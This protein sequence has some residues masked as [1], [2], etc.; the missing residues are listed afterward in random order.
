[1]ELVGKEFVNVAK[2]NIEHEPVNAVFLLD[3][4]ISIPVACRINGAC[5]LSA[6]SLYYQD[7]RIELD[8]Q[9][10]LVSWIDSCGRSSVCNTQRTLLQNA[11]IGLNALR[12]VQINSNLQ[13]A[14]HGTALTFAQYRTLLINSA[15]GYDEQSDKPNSNGKPRRS[16]FN[17]E[18]LLGDHD[19]TFE[20]N[21]DVDTT[22]DELQA[23]A[24]N[25][26]EPPQFKSG[27]RM[28]IARWKALSEQATQI[29]DTMA[30]D[31]KALI[32]ALQEKRK[33][34]PQPDQSKLSANTHTATLTP[35]T[36]S[37]NIDDVLLAMVTKHSNRLTQPSSHPW[38]ICL[39]LS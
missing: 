5:L 30:D 4:S 17:S 33:E 24:L 3:G 34:A 2:K 15:T 35:D 16:V 31:D 29:W 7:I 9:A 28:P 21:C 20:F 1:M 27:S 37:D 13:Q 14:I 32:L 39:V 12:Q 6:S 10:M 11:V 23:Y 8:W 22:A 38:D 26:W 36:P 25:W 19:E 18:T